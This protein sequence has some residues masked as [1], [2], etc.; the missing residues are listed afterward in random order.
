MFLLCSHILHVLTYS[1]SRKSQEHVWSSVQCVGR[2]RVRVPA[3]L[4]TELPTLTKIINETE[5][6]LNPQINNS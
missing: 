5:R 2:W 4:Q 3:A 1:L 6:S